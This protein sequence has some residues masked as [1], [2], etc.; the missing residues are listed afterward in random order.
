MERYTV[1]SNGLWSQAFGKWIS[2]TPTILIFSSFQ[3]KGW[4]AFSFI[5]IPWSNA[6]SQNSF[7]Q[8][9]PANQTKPHHPPHGCTSDTWRTTRHEKEHQQPCSSPANRFLFHTSEQRK[10][11]TLLYMDAKL[12]QYADVVALDPYPLSSSSQ[13]LAKGCSI[14]ERTHCYVS[15]LEHSL[16]VFPLPR[17]GQV[18][19]S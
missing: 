5:A 18:I 9:K 15:L 6:S 10:T 1:T 8:K 12:I 4:R 11:V 19:P 7:S 2:P 17:K 13:K 14:S 16:L 3:Y